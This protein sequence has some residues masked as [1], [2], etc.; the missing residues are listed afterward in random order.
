[1]SATTNQTLSFAEAFKRG[2]V[3][4]HFL[5]QVVG[6]MEKAI[7]Q[8]ALLNKRGIE[9]WDQAV[10]YYTG[11]LEGSNG[12]GEG[13]L[14]YSW[15]D[16]MCVLFNTCG[17]DSDEPS[18]L[19]YVNHK[20][21]NHFIDG[22]T[23]LQRNEC[24]LVSEK[25]NRIVEMMLVPLVQVILYEAHARSIGRD[26]GARSYAAGATAAAAILP[27]IDLCDP[28]DAEL[29]YEQMRVGRLGATDFAQVK[30]ILEKSYTCLG[31]QCAEVGGVYDHDSRSYFSDAEPC[32]PGSSGRKKNQK[33]DGPSPA[34]LAIGIAVGGAI[35]VAIIVM[36]SSFCGA[37]AAPAPSGLAP[38]GEGAEIT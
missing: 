2:T 8:C 31:I 15:A 27:Y 9:F 35:F 3:Y 29:L 6:Q 33:G 7:E 26:D 34:G 32:S 25:R 1:L 4:L 22:Q 16:K 24:D 17:E 21:I 18:G 14:L 28:A 13:V 5:I 38:T 10:A 11:S 12:L 20:V 19:S 36:M 37:K 30:N 23:S